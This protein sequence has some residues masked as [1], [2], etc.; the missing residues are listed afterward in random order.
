[1]ASLQIN[2]TVCELA[3][4][5]N[6]HEYSIA[7]AESC[8]GGG[9]AFAITNNAECSSALERGFIVYSNHAK[10]EL[11]NVKTET[12]ES[13][14]AVSAETAKEMAAGALKNSRAHISIAITGLAGPKTDDSNQP[15]GTVW[16][17]YA[18]KNKA[19]EAELHQF[20]GD[21]H[22]ICEHTIAAALKGAVMRLRQ[23]PQ[24]S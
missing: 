16:I 17:G 9:L 21:R 15:V 14:F 18:I 6:Q 2:Q 24:P 5:L 1:M 22:A 3:T 12:L 23:L 4:L 11:L 20:D 7:T 8:T 19:P 10:V 13:F